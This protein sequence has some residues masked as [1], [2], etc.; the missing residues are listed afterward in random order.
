[1]GSEGPAVQSLEAYIKEYKEKYEPGERAKTLPEHKLIKPDEDAFEEKY[2]FENQITGLA[3]IIWNENFV[4]EEDRRIGADVD[5]NNLKE[6]FE[7]LDFEVRIKKD[8]KGVEMEEFLQKVSITSKCT[9]IFPLQFDH[10]NADCFVCAIMSHG[11]EELQDSMRY[12]TIYGTD[13]N[14]VRTSHFLS[15]F[16]DECCPE[17]GGKPKL[18]F[19]QACRGTINDFGVSIEVQTSRQDRSENEDQGE[20]NQVDSSGEMNAMRY[21]VSPAQIYKDFLLMY[22]APPGHYAIRNTTNGSWMVQ[23]LHKEM[24][25]GAVL[26]HSLTRVSHNMSQKETETIP[27][28][29]CVPCIMSNLPKTVRF[30]HKK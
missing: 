5:V 19:V 12:D 29:K 25:P 20:T 8:L 6:I 23:C 4:K 13:G 30:T 11:G 2:N 14:A 3:V 10:R 17:L 21:E 18:F 24:K 15:I 1:M 28:K 26:H 7:G 27:P 16:N 9:K 22:A